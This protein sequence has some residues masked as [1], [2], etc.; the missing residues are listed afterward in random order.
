MRS[1]RDNAGDADQLQRLG[2]KVEPRKPPHE[3]MAL[4]D[5]LPAFARKALRESL[6][7]WRPESAHQNI[8]MG[9]TPEEFVAGLAAADRQLR[10]PDYVLD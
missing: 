2:I 1:R 8:A 9:A 6:G 7:D 10:H 5:A 4:F 3:R